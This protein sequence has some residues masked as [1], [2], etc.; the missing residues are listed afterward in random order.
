MITIHDRESGDAI[1]RVAAAS[2]QG[3]KLGGRRVR[4]ADL[5]GIDLQGAD[6]RKGDFWG[7]DFTG[8]DLRMSDLSHSNLGN[9]DLRGARLA[10]A[11]LEGA[12]YNSRT[13]W[14][15]GFDP[16][17]WGATLEGAATRPSPVVD[18]ADE[19]RRKTEQI[20]AAWRARGRGAD[21]WS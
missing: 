3:A 14:P 10:G 12:R 19:A 5:K 1:L 18:P 20:L 9:A 2:L 4:Y 7:S 21:A 15:E 13:R 16:Q 6:L 11:L 8:A 17:V